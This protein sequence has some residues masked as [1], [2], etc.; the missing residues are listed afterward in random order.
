MKAKVY[1]KPSRTCSNNTESTAM[2]PALHHES[3]HLR[4]IFQIGT[5]KYRVLK[6]GYG[7]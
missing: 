6:L 3:V 7:L 2:S 1:V 4:G 5:S